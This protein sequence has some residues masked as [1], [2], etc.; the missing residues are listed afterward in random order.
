MTFE[1]TYFDKQKYTKKEQLVKR[2]VLSVLKWASKI[3]KENLLCGKGKR[4]LDVGCA[5]GYTSQVLTMLGY[6]T[7]ALDVSTWGVRQAKKG[8]GGEFLVCDAQTELP[9]EVDTFDLVACFD[10]LEHLVNP[11]LALKSMFNVCGGVMICTTPNSKVEK[12]IRKLTGDYD[13]TPINVK[14][15]KEWENR[16]KQNLNC[17]LLRVE[18]FHDFA[19]AVLGKPFFKSVCIPS[20]GLTVRIAIKK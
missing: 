11:E 20:Y 17:S 1:E 13:E 19:G 14:P 2:H 10:V 6:E 4:A 8:R 3:S 15:P 9:F 16:I 18:A 7:C 5:Y 12:P